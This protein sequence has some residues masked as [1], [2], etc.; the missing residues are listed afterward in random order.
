MGLETCNV[1][2]LPLDLGSSSGEST[3]E[4]IDLLLGPCRYACDR[5]K[6]VTGDV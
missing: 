4:G 2:L 3:L 6:L 5:A 1:C